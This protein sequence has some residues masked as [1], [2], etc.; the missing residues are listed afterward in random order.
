M[1]QNDVIVLVLLYLFVAELLL[2]TYIAD[3]TSLDCNWCRIV[4]GVVL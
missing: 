3:A 2:L 1:V 4:A